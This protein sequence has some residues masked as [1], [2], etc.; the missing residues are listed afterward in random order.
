[1]YSFT[2]CKAISCPRYATHLSEYCLTHDPAQHLDSTLSSPLLDSVSLSNW[3]CVKE[4]LSD[5]RILGSLFS[6]STFREVS[7]AK[8]TILNSNFSFCLFEECTFDESTIRYV[9]FS[10]S[11]FTRCTFLNSSITH[12]NFNGS[13]ITRCDLSGSDL[14]YSSFAHS[15]LH[16]TKMEDCN[17]RKADFRHTI[18]D[19][20]SFRWSNYREMMG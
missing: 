20:L 19:N 7:F 3:K 16:D 18:Q 14:Y 1:M 12:T 4:D 5:K 9:M 13:I 15:H 8:T 10:G 2:R 11:T 6:Y 17:V